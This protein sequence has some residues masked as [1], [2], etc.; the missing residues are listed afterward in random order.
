MI[1]GIQMRAFAEDMPMT[2]TNAADPEQWNG[3][4]S[5]GTSETLRFTANDMHFTLLTHVEANEVIA[6][7]GCAFQ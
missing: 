7:G 1:H 4:T 2:K 6:T 3:V 5:C